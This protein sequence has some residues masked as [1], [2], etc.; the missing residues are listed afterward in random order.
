[1]FAFFFKWKESFFSNESSD[2]KGY[3][4]WY[5]Y[6]LHVVGVELTD[7]SKYISWYIKKMI[8]T[9]VNY[10][11]YNEFQ[12]VSDYGKISLITRKF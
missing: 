4:S 11:S 1:M 6:I 3:F 10:F 2:S 12:K 8:T 7:S 9:E 5:Y